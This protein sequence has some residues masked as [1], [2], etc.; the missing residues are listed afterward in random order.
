M[1]KETKK[2]IYVDED[3][4]IHLQR[5]SRKQRGAKFDEGD[6]ARLRKHYADEYGDGFIALGDGWL[7]GGNGSPDASTWT[8]WTVGD[9]CI[10]L[11]SADYPY[12]VGP[13]GDGLILWHW[14]TRMDHDA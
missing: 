7:G 2:V 10:M 9:M 13:V 5:E 1:A 3:G 11:L 14:P 8:S 4:W 6:E 12:G